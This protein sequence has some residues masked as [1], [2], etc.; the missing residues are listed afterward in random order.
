MAE[1]IHTAHVLAE[2]V[3]P[4]HIKLWADGLFAFQLTI[5]AAG[6]TAHHV[7]VFVRFVRAK[8]SRP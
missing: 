5:W 4:E 2:H 7:V 8:V 1:A 3:G 6:F